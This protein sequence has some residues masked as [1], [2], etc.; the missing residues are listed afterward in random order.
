[1]NSGDFS[2]DL[3]LT[4]RKTPNPVIPLMISGKEYLADLDALEQR[5][6]DQ[7]SYLQLR[8]YDFRGAFSRLRQSRSPR[9]S[10]QQ[11]AL[12]LKK[13]IAQLGDAHAKVVT[14]F[15]DP[16]VRFLPFSL[17]DTRDGPVALQAD[18]SGFIA[19]TYPFIVA[20]D[21]RAMSTWLKTASQYVAQASPQLIR[22][23][24]LREMRMID[25]LRHD[26]GVPPSEFIRLTLTSRNGKKRIIQRLALSHKKLPHGTIPIGD[27]RT[28]EANIGYLR[29]SRMKNSRIDK[30]I[31]AMHDF[32]H[33]N[34]LI[35]DVRNNTGGRYG[36][37]QALY[38][39]F[40]PQT[41]PPY[42]A[43]ITAYRLSRRFSE[44]HLH[45]RPTYTRN[46]L[47]WTIAKRQ[48][49][50]RTL[51]VF[52]PKWPLPQN[53]FSPWHF[54]V[55]GHSMS[56]QQYFYR[57]PVVVLC[58]AASFSATD[59]FLSV[60]ADLPKV[61]LIG[62]PSSGGSGAIQNFDLPQS[63]IRIALSS[64]ASFRPN[65]MLYDGNGIDVDIR[66]SPAPNDFLGK[67]DAVLKRAIARITQLQKME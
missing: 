37:L 52:H 48:A 56:S 22:H 4:T 28:L 3:V 46:H 44:D 64:M 11:F 35:I 13:L 30:V 57:Q 38:G 53:Q 24:S 10:T 49:I 14:H 20:I 34:G 33:T 47:G 63:G 59:G 5:F 12:A 65:G 7:A 39:F 54:M 19:S 43:N 45:Y 32:K 23:R 40:L 61:T 26:L 36:I 60:F 62:Q 15:D 16:N 1:M 8:D 58:N 67:T 50:Q 41:A 21:G 55:L 6:H 66:I 51:E 27:T 25:Q 18:H 17:A 42:V 9:I 29:I 2:L 31:S